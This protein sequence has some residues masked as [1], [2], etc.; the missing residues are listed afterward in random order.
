MPFLTLFYRLI[1][2]P[3]REEPLRTLLTVA[4]VALG[5]AAVLAIEL[6]GEAATGSFHASMETLASDVDFEITAVGGLSPESLTRLAALPYALK[7]HPRIEDYAV[8]EDGHT[9]PLLGVDLLSESL[10][11]GDFSK[12]SA[13]DFSKDDSVWAGAGLGLKSGDRVKLIVNDREAEVTVRGVLGEKSAEFLLMDLAQAT[14][15]LNRK[16][17]LDRILV[18]VPAG[19]EE[20]E[21]ILHQA[22]PEGTTIS[23]AGTRTE[24]NKKMLGAFRWN[25]RILSYIA[26]TVGAFLIYN[27]ISVSVVRRRVEIG[28][29]RA[30][31]ATRAAVLL[32]FLGEAASFGL[33]GALGGIALGRFMA[34]GAVKLVSLTVQQLYVS[35][36]P[37]PVVLSWETALLALIIGV[38]VSLLSAFSL[39]WEASQVSPVEAM[40]RGR[41]EYEVQMHRW[42]GLMIAALLAVSAWIAA[43]QGPIG[44]KP[45]FGYLSALLLIAASALA[46]P[47]LI[48]GLSAASAGILRQVFGVEAL[49][50]TRSLAGSLRRTSVL[51]G[52]LS[53]AIAMLTAVGIMVG[54]F[55]E[56][57]AVW[58]DDTLQA[59][60]YLSPALPAGADRNPTMPSDILGQLQALREVEAV[61]SFRAYQISYG[62][63][64]VTLGAGDIKISSAFRHR[65]SATGKAPQEVF[66][67]L[68]GRDAVMVSEPFANKH[69]VSPGDTLMLPLG[70][71]EIPFR[72]AD[73]YY[74]YTNERG[75]IVMDRATLLKYLPDTGVSNIAVYL[76]PGV[77][78]EDGRRAV[79]TSLRGHKLL[80]MSNRSIRQ[81]ALDIFDRTFAI[82]YALEAIA[83]FVAVLGVGGALLALVIDRRR[84]FGLLR[85]LGCSKIQVRRMMLFEA[86]LLGLFANI[87]GLVLGLFLSLLLIKVINKQSFGWTIQ[88]HWPVEILLAALTVVYGATIV[89]GL[90]PARIAYAVGTPLRW[91]MKSRLAACLVIVNLLSATSP[92]RVALPGYRYEFPRDHFNHPD[93]QTE[94]WY[95][96][97]NLKTA[98]GRHFGFELT[99]FRVGVDRD[100]KPA[101]VWDVRDV[102]MAHLALSD[103]EGNRF[104]HTERFNRSGAGI[105]GADLAQ[106]RVWNG[107]WQTQ[108][109]RSD[110]KSQT[111]SAFDEKFSFELQLRTEKPPVIHGANG[112]SQKSEG[113][114]HASHYISFTRLITNGTVELEGK[115]YN[116]T[117]LSW[118]DHEFFTEQLSSEQTGWDWFSL[119]F[120]DGTELMLFRLRRKDGSADPYSA[121]T[122]VDRQGHATALGHGA[123]T[124]IPGK[125]WTIYPIEWKLKVP[126]LGID[127]S[128]STRL[129][130]QQLTGRVTYWEGAIEVIGARQGVGYLEM[131]RDVKLRM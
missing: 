32:A 59:D 100:S 12:P 89:A 128:I 113:E 64:P 75:Y 20:W 84:E 35:S 43:R 118:M 46:I 86:G 13:Q 55:R 60:L 124:A 42:R 50:A 33:L 57:V 68:V 5:V 114:G 99:F 67:Q 40:S 104:L 87:A 29:L 1:L 82:T 14:R 108:W 69:R 53:T 49:L 47:A 81:Q 121:G 127:V 122:Y 130:Q 10:P 56:T 116:V 83:V 109:D 21:S 111:L 31:G 66:E 76:K 41:R 11:D 70:G 6:A 96:T 4:A 9:V 102:W 78:L 88:F 44:G 123:F 39:A 34:E 17:P 117:G 61:D 2:R 94:W 97:G 28:I 45:I 71:K 23:P 73:I 98:E 112:V 24:E 103:L 105:A 27:T 22:L 131:T 18:Q 62:G 80:I 107:N 74:D 51:V 93:F 119:Q 120:D 3:L 36:R 115:K 58:M 16:G 85:F 26:L 101:G 63:L 54:S 8:M 37:G 90:Y 92:Y 65:P 129:P 110:F 7:L 52:A 30:L 72:V 19:P 15:V 77:S 48:S 25:L 38:G 79:E 106:A 126:S 95:Y 125:Q 91:C